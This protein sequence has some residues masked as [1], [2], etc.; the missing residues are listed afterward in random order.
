MRVEIIA[1]GGYVDK[2][3]GDSVLALFGAPKSL[4]DDA[5]RAVN[6]AL[7]MQRR[8]HASNAGRENQLGVRIGI[9]TG[10]VVVGNI[11]QRGQ[12]TAIGDAVNT[13]NRVQSAAEPATVYISD[14]T[15]RVVKARFRLSELEPRMLKGKAEPVTLFR[16][17]GPLKTTERY[18]GP[19][20]VRKR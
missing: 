2:F 13:A 6:C 10:E 18:I 17:E 11:G 8:A 3:M 5:E 20:V 14:E 1:Q 15:A 9:D 12:Y 7:E 16:V 19:F 4:G